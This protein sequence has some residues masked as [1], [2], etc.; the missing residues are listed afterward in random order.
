M[1][2]CL[3]IRGGHVKIH[4]MLLRVVLPGERK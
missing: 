3:N 2:H 4:P 1:L